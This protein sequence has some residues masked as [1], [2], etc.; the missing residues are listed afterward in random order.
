MSKQP[1]T[2][3]NVPEPGPSLQKQKRGASRAP[4]STA[5]SESEMKR[6][7]TSMSKASSSSRARKK[8]LPEATIE[9]SSASDMDISADANEADA[10]RTVHKSRRPQPV[11]KRKPLNGRGGSKSRETLGE[12]SGHYGENDN[13]VLNPARRRDHSSTDTTSTAKYDGNYNDDENFFTS[14]TKG[15]GSADGTEDKTPQPKKGVPIV[16]P[17]EGSKGLKPLDIARLK[18]AKV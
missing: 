13:S 10:R 1:A 5:G 3:D 12:V 4:S 9:L 15:E 14:L 7:S 18:A 6:S 17:G 16:I 11:Q 8:P 2:S